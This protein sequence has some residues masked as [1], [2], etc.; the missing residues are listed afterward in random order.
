MRGRATPGPIIGAGL[1]VAVIAAASVAWFVARDDEPDSSPDVSPTAVRLP[2]PPSGMVVDVERLGIGNSAVPAGAVVPLVV[3][4]AAQ[5]PLA[6]LELWAN[7]VVAERRDLSDGAATR[8]TFDWVASAGDTVLTVR[9]ID[10]DGRSALSNA[11]RV[12]ATAPSPVSALLSYTIV[13]GDSLESIAAAHDTAAELVALANPG[14]FQVG[15]APVGTTVS[16]PVTTTVPVGEAAGASGLLQPASIAPPPYE[17]VV[18]ACTAT[19][20]APADAGG[21]TGLAAYLLPPGGEIFQLVASVPIGDDLTFAVPAGPG[22]LVL[23]P[24]DGTS[25]TLG[26]PQPITAAPDCTAGWTG[27]ARL[28]GTRLVTGVDADAA[29]LYID[30]GDGWV[31]VPT[32]GLVAGDDEGFDFAGLLPGLDADR[33][34]IEA[35]GRR[36]GA[37]VGLGTGSYSA[38]ELAPMPSAQHLRTQLKWVKV[39][40]AGAAAEQLATQ[41]FVPNPGVQEFVWSASSPVVTTAVWQVTAQPVPAT[42]GIDVSGVIAQGFVDGAAER[43]TVDFSKFAGTPQVATASASSSLGPLAVAG[44]AVPGAVPSQGAAGAGSAVPVVAGAGGP[45]VVVGPPVAAAVPAPSRFY[46]RLVPFVGDQFP[47]A[48]SNTVEIDTKFDPAKLIGV[49]E[50]ETGPGNNVYDLN[51]GVVP[52]T[53]PD[54]WLAK[55]WRITE[56]DPMKFDPLQASANAGWLTFVANFGDV[57]C[58]VCYPK[59][60]TPPGYVQFDFAGYYGWHCAS[61][62]GFDLSDPGT[63]DEFPILGPLM[64]KLIEGV[65]STWDFVVELALYLK[66]KVVDLVAVLGCEGFVNTA[67]GAAGSSPPAQAKAWC[68]TVAE[69][70]VDAALIYFGVPPTLPTFEEAM[71]AAEGQLVE[72]VVAQATNLGVP[73]DEAETAGDAV[74]DHTLTCAALAK[75]LLEHIVDTAKAAV[76]AS[77]SAVSGIYFPP[78]VYAVPHEGGQVRPAAVIIEVVP[79]ASAPMTGATCPATIVMS[80]TYT[81]AN[82]AFGFA[83]LPELNSGFGANYGAG[84]GVWLPSGTYSGL[85]VHPTTVQ[86]PT[87]GK[88]GG[89]LAPATAGYSLAQLITHDPVPG[90]S[91]LGTGAGATAVHVQVPY[92]SLLLHVGATLTTTVHSSCATDVTVVGVILPSGKMQVTKVIQ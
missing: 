4:A 89:A 38:P 41:G 6:A 37:L 75:A 62:D 15:Q 67:S 19:V 55:C 58:P 17:V 33:I 44:G 29:Y 72:F 74:G 35:W 77:A 52:P 7:D 63:W 53:A 46:V 70:A 27:D 2:P 34:E 86:L 22:L 91:Y 25:S 83:K 79:T 54:P 9:S 30:A 73:C 13:D 10:V 82:N 92:E 32:A 88:V 61:D 3:S 71:K 31:R 18:D 36:D 23:G 43:F 47:G 66:A 49:G 42:A 64:S 39:P 57:V 56:I 76:S 16:I 80:S 24:F 87:L 8:V 26:P 28:V 50:L 14:V 85:V 45:E 40:A 12:R 78:G 5:A 81:A 65:A 69:I 60:W 1:V 48:A 51:V 90:H 21:A 68:H 11:I 20:A 84:N 59:V